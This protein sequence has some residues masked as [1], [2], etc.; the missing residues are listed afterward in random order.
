MGSGG[1]T[2]V[3]GQQRIHTAKQAG[4]GICF[5]QPSEGKLAPGPPCEGQQAAWEPWLRSVSA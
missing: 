3:Q 5:D 1:Y 2:P 4:A